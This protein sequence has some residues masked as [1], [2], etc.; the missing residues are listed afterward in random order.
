M[1]AF[2]LAAGLGTRLRPLTNTLP[3]CLV[4]VNGIPMMGYWFS[5]FRKYGIRDIFI[6][7]NH[8]P[9]QVK[10][11]VEENKKTLNVTLIYEEQLLGSLGTILNNK[12]FVKN[13]EDFFIF[14]S[15]N[16]T[17]VNLSDMLAAHK[18]ARLPFTMGLF[19]TN[20]P[21]SCGLAQLDNNNIVVD[22]VEKPQHPVS[23]LANAGIY[24]MK[25]ELFS[26][27]IFPRGQLLDIGFNLLPLLKNRM[28]GFEIRDF[29][30]DIG[31]HKNYNFANNLLRE[32]KTLF[33]NVSL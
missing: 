3:K 22:F 6:N 31:T 2:L 7:L 33:S 26:E 20:D 8:F 29:L 9:D 13:E 5:L 17:N 24:I 14:Y 18:K 11:Y 1:K 23:D 10:A 19:R 27:L 32:D 28:L 4:P 21:R 16:L 25:P 30:L 15:D 12:K